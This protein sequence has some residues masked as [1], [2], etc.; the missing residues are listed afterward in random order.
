MMSDAETGMG[1]L[2][3]SIKYVRIY[4]MRLE[5]AFGKAKK[6][7]KQCLQAWILHIKSLASLARLREAD[8]EIS[9][10]R[11]AHRI[12]SG[13]GKEYDAVTYALKARGSL[14]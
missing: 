6:G 14:R 9:Q 8:L 12:L 7:P 13:L 4:R 2:V 10:L 1:T 3:S 11:I 5:E